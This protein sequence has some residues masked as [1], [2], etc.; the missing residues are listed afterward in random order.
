MSAAI[1]CGGVGDKRLTSMVSPR[2]R[3]LWLTKWEQ[4][5]DAAAS[6]R[7]RYDRGWGS[8]FERYFVDYAN[9]VAT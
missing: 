3:K 6:L 4:L 2:S 5:G 8:V 7:E 1:G 9:S